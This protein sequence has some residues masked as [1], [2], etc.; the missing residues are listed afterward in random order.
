MSR[1]TK[2]KLI[3]MII[4]SF[5]ITGITKCVPKDS[6]MYDLIFGDGT[7]EVTLAVIGLSVFW[8]VASTSVKQKRKKAESLRGNGKK[9]L[10]NIIGVK[11][12]KSLGGGYVWFIICEWT[13]DA[14]NKKMYFISNRLSMNPEATLKEKGIDNIPVFLSDDPEIYLVDTLS[15]IGE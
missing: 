14:T 10:A 13:D 15:I 5:I 1:D 3:A 9:I 8:F 2:E 12:A 6:K 11:S 7:G 4:A